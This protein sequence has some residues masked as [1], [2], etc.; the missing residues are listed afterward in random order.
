MSELGLEMRAGAVRYVS[1]GDRV[2]K[3]SLRAQVLALID[4]LALDAHKPVHTRQVTS[5]ELHSGS[6]LCG[7]ILMHLD[8]M[9]RVATTMDEIM[10]TA[11]HGIVRVAFHDDLPEFPVGVALALPTRGLVA[12]RG[13]LF[14][15]T[16]APPPIDRLLLYALATS[17]ARL[18]AGAMLVRALNADCRNLRDAPAL[19]AFSP[20]T[21]MRARVIRLVDDS[22]AWAMRSAENPA[23]DND[24]LR[25][26]LLALLSL[27]TMPSALDEP[28]TSWLANEAKAFARSPEYVVGNFHRAMGA[29]LRE[30]V[31][32]AD[33][34]DI[35]A[36]WARA[37]FDYPST[38]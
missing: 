37:Y 19:V 32:R 13:E 34:C 11:T 33:S 9:F 15:G 22:H 3:T 10:L 24:R 31:T 30:V 2:S 20:L 6:A 4:R 38:R 35:D 26:Q 36:L 16:P 7:A 5:T 27:E 18:G 14:A 1:A 17:P 23:V 12:T 25:D 28:V 21:G 29:S 8:L